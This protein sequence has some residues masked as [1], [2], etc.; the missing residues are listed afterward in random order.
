[1][2]DWIIEHYKDVCVWVTTIVACASAIVKLT[3]TAKD[4]TILEKIIEILSLFS[5]FNTKKDQEI[6]EKFKK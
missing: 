2:I 1:M 6:I 5:I 3:P 4:D